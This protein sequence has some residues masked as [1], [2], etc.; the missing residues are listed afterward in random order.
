MAHWAQLD[1][2]NKVI[3]VT[4]GDDNDPNGDEGYQWLIDNLGGRWIK[5]SYNSLGGV[6]TK[7]DE[8][9]TRIPSGKPHLRYNFAGIGF[10]YDS[11]KD[12]FIPPI[13][14]EL[15]ESQLESMKWELNDETCLWELWFL[16]TET[17][18]W[19]KPEGEI[20]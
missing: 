14:Y 2:N 16:N 10:T 1:E 9:G 5:T 15:N 20:E 8:N 7:I 11:V 18:T 6:H 4:V 12:A 17:N 13:P 19:Q 3:Q